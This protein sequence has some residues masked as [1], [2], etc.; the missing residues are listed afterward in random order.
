MGSYNMLNTTMTLLL[1][2]FEIKHDLRKC[3]WGQDDI[4]WICDD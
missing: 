2:L 4:G 1:F 3:D